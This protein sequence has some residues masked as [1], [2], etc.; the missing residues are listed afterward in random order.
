MDMKTAAGQARSYA[1]R[2][3]LAYYVITDAKTVSVWEF[4]GAIAPTSK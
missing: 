4:Q 1:L 2:V 3:L